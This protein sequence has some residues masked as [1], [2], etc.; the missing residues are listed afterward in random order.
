MTLPPKAPTRSLMFTKPWPLW[1]PLS[2][3]EAGA[4]VGDLEHE[5]AFHLAQRDR[6]R[7]A[8]AGVLARVLHRLE[9]AEVD[10]RLDLLRVA[11]DAL[12]LDRR[13]QRGAAGGGA[14]ARRGARG[15]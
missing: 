9:A 12:G 6:H 4:V 8:L 13:R 11:A 3:V 10:G 14:R 5:R 7:R 15:P 2:S 1:A